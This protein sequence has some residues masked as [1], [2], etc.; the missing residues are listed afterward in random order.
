MIRKY[1]EQ[2]LDT[3]ARRA[4]L[5]LPAPIRDGIAPG[6]DTTRARAEQVIGRWA[7][8]SQGAEAPPLT[9]AGAASVARNQDD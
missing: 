3:G 8:G 5:F 6:S 4:W 2:A 9:A 1:A 7:A